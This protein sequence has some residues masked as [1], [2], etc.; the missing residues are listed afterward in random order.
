MF[1]LRCAEKLIRLLKPS[2]VV[3]S[4]YELITNP[5]TANSADTDRSAVF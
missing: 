1:N 3:Q 4:I 2:R 5:S